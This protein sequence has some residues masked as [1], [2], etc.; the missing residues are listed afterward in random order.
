MKTLTVF[1]PT[2]NRAYCLHHLYDSLCS[3]TS[4]DFIWLVI[5]DGSSDNTKDLVSEWISENIIDIKYIF[6]KNGGM[7][8][9]HNIA[10]D[11]IDTEINVCIDSD[12][13]MPSNAVSS[14]IDSWKKTR[15]DQ[16]IVGMVGVDVDFNGN[17]IGSYLPKNITKEK[18]HLLYQKHKVTGDKKVVLRTSAL[19]DDIRYPVFPNERLVPLGY[20]YHLLDKEYYY[21]CVNQVWVEVDYQEAGS[22]ATI[23]RQ[24]FQSPNGF[25]FVKRYTYQNSKSYKYKLK[26]LIHF[27][28]T[29]IILKDYFFIFKSPNPLASLCLYPVSLTVYQ[30][31][32]KQLSK[33]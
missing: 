20:L 4:K 18:F 29:S 10:Y 8:T 26:A 15:D 22:S 2:Y 31:K 17:L 3:Q 1:T 9:A 27:G 24:Y 14:I 30:F 23:N 13:R 25:R 32:K 19:T 16:S 33:N 6:K 28:F 11:N 12:D 5:D 21:Y 7:H